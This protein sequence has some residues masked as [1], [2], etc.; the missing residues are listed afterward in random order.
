[1]CAVLFV[2]RF[3]ERLDGGLDGDGSV[4]KK[5]PFCL[6]DVRICL[7]QRRFA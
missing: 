6:E 2:E 1:M 7:L 4:T 5:A 3:G